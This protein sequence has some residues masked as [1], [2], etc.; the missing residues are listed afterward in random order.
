MI[1]LAVEDGFAFLAYLAIH[2]SNGGGERRVRTK[3]RMTRGVKAESRVTRKERQVVPLRAVNF[4]LLIPRNCEHAF[5][6]RWN[7]LADQT[8]TDRRRKK[9]SRTKSSRFQLFFPPPIR[10]GRTWSLFPNYGIAECAFS[11]MERKK[12]KRKDFNLTIDY[13]R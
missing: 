13:R 3:S 5:Q 4:L 7:P 9:S 8:P 11:I 1:K 6:P 12:K 2:L 10:L